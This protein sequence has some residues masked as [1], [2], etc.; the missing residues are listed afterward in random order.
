MLSP[1]VFPVTSGMHLGEVRLGPAYFSVCH[2]PYAHDHQIPTEC[3]GRVTAD[4]ETEKGLC[5]LHGHG[6]IIF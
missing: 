3:T 2:R 1:L 6:R 5:E 4:A